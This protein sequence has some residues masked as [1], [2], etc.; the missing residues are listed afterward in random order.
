MEHDTRTGLLIIQT[1]ERNKYIC[2]DK[3]ETHF[4][5]RVAASVTQGEVCVA[6]YAENMKLTLPQYTNFSLHK[7]AYSIIFGKPTVDDISRYLYES[8]IVM[9]FNKPLFMAELFVSFPVG[10]HHYVSPSRMFDIHYQSTHTLTDSTEDKNRL[11][12]C[13][14]LCLLL[15][16]LA[17]TRDITEKD[18]SISE[19]FRIYVTN[20]IGLNISIE[21]RITKC[22]A[23]AVDNMFLN[24]IKGNDTI[25]R[26]VSCFDLFLNRDNESNISLLKTFTL[27]TAYFEMTALSK[28]VSLSRNNMEYDFITRCMVLPETKDTHKLVLSVVDN[29]VYK[30][31]SIV[32]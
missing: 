24:R 26:L 31:D 15:H 14:A 23:L 7:L 6:H 2:I 16:R 20:V 30:E 5:N 13:F 19:K 8:L 9:P 27:K 28:S 29:Y 12:M 32:P 4:Q 21:D 3:K 1:Q 17:N 25:N 11:I 18:S 10:P 22:L